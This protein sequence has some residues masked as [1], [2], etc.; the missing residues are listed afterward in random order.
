[1][2]LPRIASACVCEV[3]YGLM[4]T[5]TQRD[6]C[7]RSN[8]IGVKDELLLCLELVQCKFINSTFWSLSSCNYSRSNSSVLSFQRTHLSGVRLL[9]FSLTSSRSSDE[10]TG[11]V[12]L[13]SRSSCSCWARYWAG[14][15][16]ASLAQCSNSL[17]RS[18]RLAY[19]W[20]QH[21]IINRNVQ[22]NTE[23]NCLL[24]A[25][26]RIKNVHTVSYLTSQSKSQSKKFKK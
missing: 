11:E 9:P 7:M 25:R 3:M 13:V 4:G 23:H 21:W 26:K 16:L 10:S 18:G 15:C 6:L 8:K 2:L 14:F 19:R 24:W 12:V 5:Y 1:M 20:E 22:C 17:W